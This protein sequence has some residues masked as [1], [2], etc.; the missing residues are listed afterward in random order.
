MLLVIILSYLGLLI[1]FFLCSYEEAL[2]P[3]GFHA[4]SIVDNELAVD[5]R[6]VVCLR[7]C[8]RFS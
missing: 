5:R 7:S 3:L 8:A 6:K 2:R 1:Y 4:V